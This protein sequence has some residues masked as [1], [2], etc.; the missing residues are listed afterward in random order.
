MNQTASNTTSK[1][2]C[3]DQPVIPPKTKLKCAK[4][5]KGHSDWITCMVEIRDDRIMSGSEDGKI[6][7]WSL[8]ESKCLS[9]F[10]EHSDA[11]LDMIQFTDTKA[12][13][14]SRDKDIKMFTFGNMKEITTININQPFCCI[15]SVSDTLIAVGGGD[16]AIRVF[17]LSDENDIP[18]CEILEGHKNQVSV[19]KLI[20]E[21]K[22]LYA[23][24]STDM[25][26]K[27]WNFNKKEL[28]TT[29]EGHTGPINSLLLLKNGLLA[30]GSD[31]YTIKLWN[32]ITNKNELT[33]QEINGH[34]MCLGQLSNNQL[35]SGS[36][37]WSVIVWNMT[38]TAEEFRVEGHGEGVGVLLVT[39]LGQLVTGS[40]DSTIKV[41]E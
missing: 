4:T 27:I 38:T 13:S 6:K 20:D 19:I 37:D 31:D 5:L 7:L 22:S 39:K 29:L 23:S 17:N 11:V 41:W 26:I 36:S 25:T 16:N 30:S 8:A 21:E 40:N 2:L 18:E 34:P 32:L 10:K 33:F 35:V 9:E 24:G 1:K 15:C 14:V 28:I 3:K 12:I